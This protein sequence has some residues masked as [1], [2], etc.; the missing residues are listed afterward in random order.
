MGDRNPIFE[1]L[2][3]DYSVTITIELKKELLEANSSNHNKR[4]QNI[5][6]GDGRVE[7]KKKPQIGLDDIFA[8]QDTD[9]YQ[10][11]ETPSCTTDI[12]LAP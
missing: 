11:N 7:F 5:L 4:G 3:S 6:F 9:V 8:L 1:T 2:P 10:G 12:F